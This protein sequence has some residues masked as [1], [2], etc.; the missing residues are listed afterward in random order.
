[1]SVDKRPV[2]VW[3]QA[4]REVLDEISGPGLHWLNNPITL[5][6]LSQRVKEKAEKL[7]VDEGGG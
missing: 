3:D 7:K 6:E 5:E 4:W 1:M 2:S